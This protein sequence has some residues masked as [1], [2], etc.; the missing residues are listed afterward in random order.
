MEHGKPIAIGVSAAVV[1]IAIIVV[2]NVTAA[3][4][5]AAAQSALAEVIR[6][7]ATVTEDTSDEARFQATLTEAARVESDYPDQPATQIARYFAGLSHQG[8]EKFRSGDRDFRRVG[9]IRR[10]DD[11]P[12]CTCRLG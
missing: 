1:G 10:R 6:V 2:L 7:Y 4:R 12:G 11:Q 8:L 3:N 9:R 5:E